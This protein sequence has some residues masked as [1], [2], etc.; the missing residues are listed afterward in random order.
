MFEKQLWVHEDISR[1]HC[2]TVNF[3]FKLFTNI[4]FYNYFYFHHY[5][6]YP[7]LRSI[8]F[9]LINWSFSFLFVFYS[10]F[11]CKNSHLCKIDLLCEFFFV[12]FGS[13]FQNFSSCKLVFVQKFFWK[14]F[15]S[16]IF[17]S[18]Q[19]SL[20]KQFSILVQF[21]LCAIFTCSL[22]I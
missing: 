5:F 10:F 9:F 7:F 17:A 4:L 15:P 1:R 6:L 16:C 19:F 22:M 12:Q 18:V 21:C 2:C 8:P 11:L 20:L 14:F 3:F 13:L